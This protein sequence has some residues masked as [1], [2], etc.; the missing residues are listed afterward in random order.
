MQN[1]N[2]E[3]LIDLCYNINMRLKILSPAGDM[4]SL[5]M[6]VNNGADEVYLGVKD[7]NA[8]NIEGF[9]LESLKQAVEF[10]HIFDVKVHLTVN[11]LFRDDEIQS[12]L[13][14]VVDAYNLGVDAFIIQDI[15]LISLVHKLYPDIEIHASTQMGIHNLE[16]VKF[17]EKFGVKRVVLA[18]ETPLSEIKRIRDNSSIEIEYFVQ[19]ALCVS[20]SGNCYMSEYITGNSGNRGKCKQL[21]RLP[22]EFMDKGKI[23]AKGYLLSAKDFNMLSKL[24]ELKNA[25]VDAIKIEGRARRPYYVGE[26]TRVYANAVRGENVDNNLQLAFNRGYTAGYFDGNG[27]IISK[28]QSHIGINI[29]E[30]KYVKNGK[31]FNEIF[32]SSNRILSPKSVF[33]IFRDGEELTTLTAY[34]ISKEKGLYRITTTQKLKLKDSVNLILDNALEEEMKNKI[35]RKNIKINVFAMENQKITAKFTINNKK[36]E[37]FGPVCSEAK[38]SPLTIDELKNNFN[39]SEYFNVDLNAT[40]ENVFMPKSMLNE[41]RRNVFDKIYSALTSVNHNLVKH[42]KLENLDYNHNIFEDFQ[43][44]E[45]I[46]EEYKSNNIIYSPEV[47]EF[48]DVKKFIQKCKEL[49][50]RPFLDMIN[51]AL[52][53]DI[54]YLREIVEKTNIPIIVNNAWALDFNV[55]KVLGWGMNIYNS[56]SAK[57]FDLPY[58]KA[59]GEGKNINAPYM[60]LRHCPMKEHL[61]ANCSACPYK[62]GY[63]YRCQSGKILRLKRKKLSTCTFY[64]VNEK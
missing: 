33:K 39:K 37:I 20:F 2:V 32:I 63:S 47:Y 43:I 59:E 11:I 21:C 17:L 61:R 30:V 29:G 26:V 19:G 54:E 18:R 4:E 41:F 36:Y 9:S 51:F 22:Y 14:L 6:A 16:G 55:D 3:N 49:N 48:N 34:D 58:M 38:N 24:D 45:N 27:D 8:R 44:V 52:S 15:G 53:E 12:A 57:C 1:F 60:T 10:A 35:L 62:D 56:Y 50:K 46:D 42:T 13:D 25:G 5:K 28:Y 31:K 40:I 64:L 7:F 23:L